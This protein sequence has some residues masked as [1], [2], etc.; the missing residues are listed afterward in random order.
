[1]RIGVKWIVSSTLGLALIIN[2]D[3]FWF[4]VI[5]GAVANALAAKILKRILHVPRPDTTTKSDPGMP[6]SH[7][8]MLAYFSAYAYLSGYHTIGIASYLFAL[9]VSYERVTRGIHSF[10]QCAVGLVS[11]SI[12]AHLWLRSI[13]H[14]EILALD[15]TLLQEKDWKV[16]VGIVM[17]IFLSYLV[18]A[19]GGRFISGR[20]HNKGRQQDVVDE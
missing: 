1:M 13:A 4:S 15:D 6:S 9:A 12:G 7:A 2:Q 14:Q 16:M 18:L 11:G 17:I 8:H 10:D 3:G 19:K 20:F 5:I